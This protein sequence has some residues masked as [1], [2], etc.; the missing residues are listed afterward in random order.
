MPPTNKPVDAEVRI[1]NL[2]RAVAELRGGTITS[3]GGSVILPS[4]TSLTVTDPEGQVLAT[5]GNLGTTRGDG[6]PEQGFIFRRDNGATAISVQ[7]GAAANVGFR[8]FV[9]IWDDSVAVGADTSNRPVV[10]TD[11]ASGTGLATPYVPIGLAVNFEGAPFVTGSAWSDL[12]V[13]TFYK[14]HPK[15]IVTTRGTTNDAA[16]TGEVRVLLDDVQ[17]GSTTSYAFGIAARQFGPFAVPGKFLSQHTIRV[18]GRVTAGT[19]R[20][21]GSSYAL[22]V[23]S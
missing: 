23:Q 5:I 20:V 1:A 11:A 8:Q 19:G 21:Q 2:E 18:Q 12:E 10:S 7:G 9:A 4:G 16:T 17:V 15:A 14:Q 13:G 22:G 3:R 6:E